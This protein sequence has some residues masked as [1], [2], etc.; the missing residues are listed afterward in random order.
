VNDKWTFAGLLD[1]P[2]LAGFF[3]GLIALRVVPGA[4]MIERLYTV[5]AACILAGFTSPAVAEYFGVESEAMR[6]AVSFLIGLFGLNFVSS[7][8]EYIRSLDLR[9][10]FPWS[11]K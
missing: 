5:I 9:S 10:V 1:N 8:T 4:T 7:G 2:F 6:S 3:G 11:K